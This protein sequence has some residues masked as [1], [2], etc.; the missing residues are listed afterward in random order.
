MVNSGELPSSHQHIVLE[1]SVGLV[2]LSWD[3]ACWGCSGALLLEGCL[4]LGGPL[5]TQI[6]RLDAQTLGGLEAQSLES[7]SLRTLEAQKCR[8]LE[9]NQ[10]KQRWK[11]IPTG[12]GHH[13]KKVARRHDK[14]HPLLEALVVWKPCLFHCYLTQGR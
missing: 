8:G 6:W 5:R 1:S 14:Y 2:S 12:E 13:L 3:R 10:Q 11:G 4:P 7:R 9:V